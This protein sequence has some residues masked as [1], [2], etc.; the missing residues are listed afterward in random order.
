MEREKKRAAKKEREIKAKS[1]LRQK[2]SVIATANNI[3]NDEELHLN[4]R[5]WEEIHEK[6][7]EHFQ[8]Q[9]S[10]ESESEPMEDSEDENSD[11]DLD[12]VDSDD[13]A[14]DAKQI[15]TERMAREMERN[16][17]K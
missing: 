16:I 10:G 15:A 5:I 11:A 13:S 4:P 7:F 14:V 12:A 1:D 6:G 3:Y 8:A 2:M 9:E 17:A